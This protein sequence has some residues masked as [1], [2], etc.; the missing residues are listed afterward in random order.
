[1]K[2]PEAKS[3]E[4][5][6][7]WCSGA[8][9]PTSGRARALMSSKTDLRFSPSEMGINEGSE[10]RRDGSPV[11]LERMLRLPCEQSEGWAE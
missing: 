9:G 4:C 6:E 2:G 5:P 11:C 8:R 7:G 3:E 1:M 10:Q